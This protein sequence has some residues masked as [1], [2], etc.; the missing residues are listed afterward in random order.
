MQ[1]HLK[2]RPRKQLLNQSSGPMPADSTFWAK[3][4]SYSAETYYSWTKSIIS[5]GVI[6]DD[7]N[8]ETGSGAT[9]ANESITIEAG[10]LV[11]MWFAGYAADGVTPRYIFVTGGSG[12]CLPDGGDQYM[13]LQRDGSGDAVWDYVRAH[14]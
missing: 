4:G 12:S 1:I 8:T 6:I 10:T 11:V 3:L 14:V 13:V 2:H 7:P 5:D 9:D